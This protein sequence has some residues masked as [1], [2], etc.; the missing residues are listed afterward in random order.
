VYAIQVNPINSDQTVPLDFRDLVNQFK[1]SIEQNEDE[2][3]LSKFQNDSGMFTSLD[4]FVEAKANTFLDK[5]NFNHGITNDS[6]TALFKEAFRIVD[7]PNRIPYPAKTSIDYSFISA[8]SQDDYIDVFVKVVMFAINFTKNPY[9]SATHEIESDLDEEVDSFISD[10]SMYNLFQLLTA[11]FHQKLQSEKPTVL[12]G[13]FRLLCLRNSYALQTFD[14]I[15]QNCSKIIKLSKIIVLMSALIL[16]KEVFEYIEKEASEYLAPNKPYSM[17]LIYSYKGSSKNSADKKLPRIATV[18]NDPKSFLLDGVKIN[19]DFFPKA[20][21]KLFERIKI[22]IEFL[23]LG[24]DF[25]DA[26]ASFRDNWKSDKSIGEAFSKENRCSERILQKILQD[27]TLKN[28][29]FNVLEMDPNW[30]EGLGF[31][32]LVCSFSVPVIN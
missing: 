29:F 7:E 18:E 19:L 9:F 12:L 32:G 17:A 15:Q 28:K 8:G 4:E 30:V 21:A 16:E 31:W 25:S 10:P 11:I 27:P 13:A 26:L 20:Y 1:P 3:A 6:L 24:E 14:V 5:F 23:T 2:L 22:N